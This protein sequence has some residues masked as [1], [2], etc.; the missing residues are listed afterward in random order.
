LEPITDNLQDGNMQVDNPQ[1]VVEAAK[2]ADIDESLYSR[3]L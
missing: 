1:E 3:Q 2:H